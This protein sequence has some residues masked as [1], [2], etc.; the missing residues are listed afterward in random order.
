MNFK[1]VNHKI[2]SSK[3]KRS[4]HI[5]TT[6]HFC[7]KCDFMYYLKA[8]GEEG[9]KLVH[10]CRHCGHEADELTDADVCVLTTQVNRGAE[11][12]AHVINEFTKEDPTVPRINTM[13]CPNQQCPANKGDQGQ[14]VLYI[15]YD[16]ANM[17][18]VYMCANCDTIW[19]TNEQK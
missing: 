13:R 7:S 9:D 19:K 6:M 15:R 14:E 18:Y 5:S 4:E 1:I 3:I 10:Y 2:A 17:K 11:K 16:D 8:T 12:Y